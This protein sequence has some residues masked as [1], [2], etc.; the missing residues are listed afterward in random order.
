MTETRRASKRD[1][2]SEAQRSS[3]IRNTQYDSLDRPEARRRKV[4]HRTMRSRNRKEA[5]R[6][7]NP[8]N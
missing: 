3:R 4:E 2:R 6:W 1:T 5:E 7:P 8:M